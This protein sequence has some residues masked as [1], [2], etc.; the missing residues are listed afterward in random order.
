M[1]TVATAAVL[2]MLALPTWA[3]EIESKKANDPA[4]ANAPIVLSEVEMDG[5]TAGADGI[6]GSQTW[7]SLTEATSTA[8]SNVAIETFEVA[9][10]GLVYAP[11]K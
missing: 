2:M 3:G 6:V 11:G 7:Q 8:T 9:H 5:I 1:K 10:D 4:N